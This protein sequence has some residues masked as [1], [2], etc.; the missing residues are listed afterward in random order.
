[1]QAVARVTKNSF[2]CGAGLLP[3][4]PAKSVTAS[5]APQ[6][7]YHSDPPST[8]LPPRVLKARARPREPLRVARRGPTARGSRGWRAGRLLASRHQRRPSPRAR[9]AGRPSG[10]RGR[11][12]WRGRIS[13]TERAD[14]ADG[15]TPAS[16]FTFPGEGGFIQECRLTPSAKL[17][18]FAGTVSA[19]AHDCFVGSANA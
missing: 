1:M 17:R 13:P 5:F 9:A 8:G 11:P 12:S 3:G 10:E 19:A 6:A 2:R 16:P 7:S 14:S 15:R 18:S 4:G